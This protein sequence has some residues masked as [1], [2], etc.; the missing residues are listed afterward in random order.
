MRWLR[1]KPWKLLGIDPYSPLYNMVKNKDGEDVIIPPK[2]QEELEL[3]KLVF[4]DF[5]GFEKGLK[6]TSSLFD[7]S[8]EE[9]LGAYDSEDDSDDED[10]AMR[11][12][13][14]DDLFFIDDA[15]EPLA[16]PMD[17]DGDEMSDSDLDDENCAWIDSDD[18]RVTVSLTDSDRL[19]KLRRSETDSVVLGRSYVTRLR[20]QFEKLYPRPLWIDKMEEKAGKAEDNEHSDSSDDAIDNED[21]DMTKEGENPDSNS[22]LEIINN[23]LKFVAHKQ[24][25]LISATRISIGR[26]KN[27]NHKRVSKSGIQS[28]SFHDSHPLL[29]TGGFDR[30]LRIYHIDGKSNNFVTSLHLRNSPI[31]V[32]QFAPVA[33]LE[34]GGEQRNLIFAGG[35]RRYMHK[36]D[37]DSGDVEKISR[38]YGHEDTQRSFE[39]FKVSPKGTYIG[40]TGNSGWCNLLSGVSGQWVRGFKI[41]GT[42]VD[43][44]FASD[45]SF[46]II[47]NS[48]GEVWEYDLGEA[49]MSSG[50]A[51]EEP[52]I[53]NQVLR[54][55]QDESGVGITKIKLGG[56][57]DKWLAIGLNTGIVNIYDRTRIGTDVNTAIKP[58]K[59][60]EN[61]VTTISTLCFSSDGQ[62]LCIASRGKRDALR[63]VHLP[64]CTV[65]SNWPT[66]G[67]PLG[68]VT[69][70]SFSPNMKLLAIGNEGGRVTLWRLNHY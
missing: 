47:V 51:L 17:I 54:R 53:Q 41:E 22:V 38:M 24:L 15:A 52:R 44:E 32:C 19:K 60:I 70:A 25:K 35:R 23:T 26:L 67:T 5:S 12:V 16:D 11:N 28:L 33:H 6:Q 64:S 8:S 48:A 1:Q 50:N 49:H 10:G 9:D 68:K 20:S 14:D 43:F 46:I 37:L 18:E 69:A 58:V 21:E 3:E 27:A 40:L 31:S 45:E 39:N 42:I 55:W 36:W 62:L 34:N 4:G 63:L 66:S 65:Y 7:Y 59:A 61:L 2:D 56:P 57:K 29:M 30:T 13:G